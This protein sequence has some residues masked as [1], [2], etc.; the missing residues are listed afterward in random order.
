MSRDTGQL[1]AYEIPGERGAG[2]L[3]LQGETIHV[4]VQSIPVLSLFCREYV[5]EAFLEYM[6]WPN[7]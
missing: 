3:I 2:K 5:A 1:V 7:S 6:V 4:T